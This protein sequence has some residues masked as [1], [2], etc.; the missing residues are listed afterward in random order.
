MKMLFLDIDGVLNAVGTADRISEEEITT[1][2][3]PGPYMGIAGGTGMTGM[4]PILIA[5]L[6]RILQ[7][8][9]DVQ[10]ILS[11]SWRYLFS[12]EA[13]TGLMKKRGFIGQVIDSTNRASSGHRGREIEEWLGLQRSS[14]ERYVILDDSRDMLESQMPFFVNTDYKKGLSAADAE[15]TIRILTSVAGSS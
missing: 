5:N 7:A 9:P 15:A 10:V 8:V 6:N 2:M 1:S 3:R 14:V 12:P 11:S 4:D 13:L